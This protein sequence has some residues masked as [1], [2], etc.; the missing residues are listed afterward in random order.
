[1]TEPIIDPSYQ[2]RKAKS[3][4]LAAAILDLLKDLPIKALRAE[5]NGTIIRTFPTAMDEFTTPNLSSSTIEDL[6]TLIR[7]R[8]TK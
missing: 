5:H 1:M 7:E 8:M 3:E 2:D 4:A 6:A